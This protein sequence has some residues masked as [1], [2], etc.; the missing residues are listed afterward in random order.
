MSV[1]HA[2]EEQS[3]KETGIAD[4][5]LHR[6]VRPRHSLRSHTKWEHPCY[7][8]VEECDVQDFEEEVDG[9]GFG[10]GQLSA[11]WLVGHGIIWVE[12]SNMNVERE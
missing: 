7:E 5:D 11:S 10:P 8:R 1:E 4:G 3:C 12:K 2:E 6:R 9:E